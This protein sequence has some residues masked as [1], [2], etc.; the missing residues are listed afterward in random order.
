MGRLVERLI[1]YTEKAAGIFLA[2][3]TVLIFTSITLRGTLGFTIP[4][5]YDLSRLMLGVC[6]FW[7]IAATSYR[8]D[9]IKVDI[10]WEWL[11]PSG[12]RWLDVVASL[13][14]LGFLA[15]F[16]WMLIQKIGSGYRSGEQT[17]DLRI[18]IWPFHLV[19]ACGIFFATL[20]MVIRVY[21]LISGYKE[22]AH[23]PIP[24]VE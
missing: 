9:H 1:D 15:V 11:G 4:E 17:F 8:N 18:R 21:R 6:I 19:A 12:R 24:P 10:L 2:A 23:K 7:G 5:W 20:L 22:P 14:L 3:I 16:S 13:I